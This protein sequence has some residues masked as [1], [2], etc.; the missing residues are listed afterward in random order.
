[1]RKTRDPNFGLIPPPI[2]V[3]QKSFYAKKKQN[4]IQ[5]GEMVQQ[6]RVFG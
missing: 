1:M 4:A 6:S 3:F 2:G 5:E